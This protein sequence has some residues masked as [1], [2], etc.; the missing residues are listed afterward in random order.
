ME[1]KT[2]TLTREDHIAVLTFDRPQVLN[3]LNSTVLR[4]LRQ[5]LE[6]LCGDRMLRALIVT[7]AGERA[8]VAGADI[9]QMLDMGPLDAR[10]FMQQGQAAINMLEALPAPV[11]A[12]VNGFAL[13]GGLELA[14][15]CDIIVASETATL[16]L[17][18]VTLGL[19]PGFGGTQRLARLV[20]RNWAKQLI[21]TGEMIDANQAQAIG[22]VNEVLPAEKLMERARALAGTMATNGP[23]AVQ[24]AKQVINRGIETDL[25]TGL[26]LEAEAEA[27]M[28][29]TEDRREGMLAFIE[30][31]KADFNGR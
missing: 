11:V 26:A 5:L 19:F 31:R 12:A 4:E 14:L 9:K 3:A 24:F 2:L 30:K 21:L 10:A 13:G 18:E 23:L 7:G 22:L 28:F 1:Y 27:T 15:A 20:G 8:F 29:A 17:P 6:E 16:G 25:G